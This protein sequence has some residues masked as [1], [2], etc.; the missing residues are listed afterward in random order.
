MEITGHIPSPEVLGSGNEEKMRA[1]RIAGAL[2]LRLTCWRTM[3]QKSLTL[4]RTGSDSWPRTLNI[5][6]ASLG[7]AYAGGPLFLQVHYG[8]NLI[9]NLVCV[10][11]GREQQ[12]VGEHVERAHDAHLP[13]VVRV[14]FDDKFL[15]EQIGPI[16]S[17]GLHF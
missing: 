15:R 9:E 16:G 10:M 7:M 4:A 11:S 13:N 6:P 5:N 8:R 12:D 2:F 17:S 14:R 1:T 3:D